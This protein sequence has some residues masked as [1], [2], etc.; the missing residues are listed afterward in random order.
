MS[1]GLSVGGADEVAVEVV[2]VAGG[3]GCGCVVGVAALLLR[4][5]LGRLPVRAVL[6]G[7]GFVAGSAGFAAS[8]AAPVAAV[9]GWA[10]VVVVVVL[11]SLSS[12][13]VSV[14][15]AV[16]SGSGSS[17]RAPEEVTRLTPLSVRSG[18][19]GRLSS[20]GAGPPATGSKVPAKRTV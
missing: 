19:V 9:D 8:V 14:L 20:G 10:V 4:R 13:L 1:R 2:S 15:D 6:T 16:V 7:S 11:S 3:L 17:M 5:P 18:S 12:G